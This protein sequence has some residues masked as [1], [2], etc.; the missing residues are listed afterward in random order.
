MVALVANVLVVDVDVNNCK[1]SFDKDERKQTFTNQIIN[2]FWN[3]D[4]LVCV[5]SW[6]FDYMHP[7]PSPPLELAPL[8]HILGGHYPKAP[9]PPIPDNPPHPPMTI[10]V[11]DT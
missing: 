7:I 5:A 8:S 1:F 3:L 2:K 9:H 6:C 4:D 11:V 10:T